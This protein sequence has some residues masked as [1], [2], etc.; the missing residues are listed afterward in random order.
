V[1]ELT[2]VVEIG[3]F[4]R[5]PSVVVGQV[6]GP[7]PVVLTVGIPGVTGVDFRIAQQFIR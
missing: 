7:D 3:A 6:A 2:V 1:K 5:A 4:F